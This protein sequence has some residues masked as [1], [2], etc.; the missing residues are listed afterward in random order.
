MKIYYIPTHHCKGGRPEDDRCPYGVRDLQTEACYDGN[1]KNKC[2]YFV[3]Y[4]WSK[5]HSGCIACTHPQKP[6]YVQLELFDH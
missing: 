4:D 3:R 1:G 5:E 6:K 2:P